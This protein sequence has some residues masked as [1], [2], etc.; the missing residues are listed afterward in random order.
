MASLDSLPPDQRAVLQLVLQRGRSYD[1]I[2]QM[3]SIDR[4]AVRERALAAFDAIG[5]QTRVGP[6]RRALITDYLLGQLPPRVAE[7][8]HD[9]LGESATERAW[10]RVLASE[11]GSLAQEP[12]PEIP[13]DAS[14]RSHL[15]APAPQD[16]GA[17]PVAVGSGAEPPRQ[18]APDPG[19]RDPSDQGPAPSSRRGGAILLG[20]GALVAII[21][22]VIII[23]TSGGSDSKHSNA[24]TSTS[25]AS[26]PTTPTTA[27]TPTTATTPSPTPTTGT[28]TTAAKVIGQVNL[29]SPTSAKGV[30]GV[31]QVV[32]Q[33]SQVGVVIVAQGVPANTKH[34]AYA[35][36]LY[37]SASNS[38]FLGFVNPGVKAD[39]KLQTAGVLPTNASSYKQLL[40]TDETQPKPAA[41]GKI[42]LQGA[43]SIS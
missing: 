14:R 19:S 41:P 42:V 28:G 31:A 39:G 35:V 22:V 37:N 8:T 17:E 7:Q 40:V 21:V 30:T 43:I 18:A 16:S 10:A 38:K 24:S 32:Q 3:L 36:W 29:S 25:V 27:S 33:G 26:T 2:A 34:D 6:E 15:G 12:L 9:R 11:L 1:Q 5:P 23:A 13:V 4:A 20:L